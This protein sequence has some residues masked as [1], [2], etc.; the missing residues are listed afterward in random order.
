[1]TS[2]VNDEIC[3]M[4]PKGQAVSLS[5]GWTM[6]TLSGGTRTSVLLGQVVRHLPVV[7]AVENAVGD[8]DV[9]GSHLVDALWDADDG[10][11]GQGIGMGEAPLRSHGA[12]GGW[13]GRHR[14]WGPCAPGRGEHRKTKVEMLALPCM[15]GWPL[16]ALYAKQHSA[17]LRQCLIYR[18]YFGKMNLLS[19]GPPWRWGL[20]CFWGI[21]QE[22]KNIDNESSA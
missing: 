5:C 13:A 21:L 7:I 10:R 4:M 8:A 17:L 2:L 12:G 6:R 14:G 20:G 18:L 19:T 1:M 15:V 11:R 22:N 3:L 16:R 9:I